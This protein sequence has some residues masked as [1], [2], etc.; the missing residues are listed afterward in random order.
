MNSKYSLFLSGIM[1]IASISFA[2]K[3]QNIY[4]LKNNGKEVSL[5]DSA[6]FI[7]IIQEPDS[8]AT[9]FNL[10][11]YYPDN[12]K[13]RL[14]KVSKFEPALVYEGSLISY[15]PNGKKAEI[16]MYEKGK[17]VG[18]RFFFY[19]NGKLQK[20]TLTESTNEQPDILGSKF[21]LISYFDSTGVQLITN[22]TGHY[23]TFEEKPNI[24]EEGDYQD[25][26]KHG[27]CKGVFVSK[28]ASFEERY[29]N[30][31]FIEGVSILEDGSSVKYSVSEE[32]PTFKGGI[33][34]FLQYV[35]RTFKYPREAQ[36]AGVSGRVM[37]SFV[38]ESNGN[39]TDIKVLRDIGY[40]TGAE[41]I[42]VVRQSAKWIPGK[43]HGIPVRVQYTLPI[44]LQQ[45]R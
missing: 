27:I 22:G 1:L 24:I 45:N 32:L 19:K 18:T 5:K 20:S 37:V 6:D 4:Y 36:Q 33:N 25:G 26:L 31:K 3:K 43:Q 23:K 38:V 34:N 39:L 28:K 12:V 11:E 41:A 30:G 42:R 15:H 14:G 40:G 35:G 16:T 2:Q 10:F 7:R 17:P 9:Y 21:K 29:E 8:G 13:K 44:M